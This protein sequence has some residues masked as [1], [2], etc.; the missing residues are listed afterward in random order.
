MAYPSLTITQDST[1][2][3]DAGIQ[4]QRATNGALK[5]RRLYSADKTEFSVVHLLSSAE[6]AALESF[7][8]ANRL[9]TF[10]FLWPLDGQTYTVGF[11]AA[12]KYSRAP[13]GFRADV[14]LGEV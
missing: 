1:A 10:T 5:R 7:Y 8:Q 11:M 4:A 12:P 2:E 9:T 14:R 13:N 6:M 3:R